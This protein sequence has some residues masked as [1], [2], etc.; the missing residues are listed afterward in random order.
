MRNSK[1]LLRSTT[2]VAIAQRDNF[3]KGD[4]SS[5]TALSVSRKNARRV[6]MPGA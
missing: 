6:K 4:S 5:A 2:D 3:P 1:Q